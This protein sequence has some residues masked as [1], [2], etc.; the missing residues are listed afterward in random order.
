MPRLLREPT[1]DLGS[2][3][4]SAG[5]TQK[6]TESVTTSTNRASTSANARETLSKH[7]EEEK[8]PTPTTPSPTP[9]K[10]DS[11]PRGAQ[12]EI[13]RHADLAGPGARNT[14]ES[15]QAEAAAEE[16]IAERFAKHLLIR[17][18]PRMPSTLI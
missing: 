9:K 2:L 13:T 14:R 17:V 8:V 10:S 3:A 18:E 11:G 16:S 15:A 5:T 12:A 4:G 6:G 1:R 7:Q